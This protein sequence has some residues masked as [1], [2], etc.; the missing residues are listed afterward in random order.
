MKAALSKQR[1]EKTSQ[2]TLLNDPVALQAEY[3]KAVTE[4]NNAQRNLEAAQSVQNALRPMENAL[5]LLRH[6]H[7]AGG[8]VQQFH[9]QVF[10]QQADALADKSGRS[11]QLLRRLGKAGFAHHHGEHPQVVGRRVFM[12]DV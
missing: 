3:D 7:A 12:H 9:G 11:A 4:R 2:L 1:L 5:A 6:A 8:A 10:L